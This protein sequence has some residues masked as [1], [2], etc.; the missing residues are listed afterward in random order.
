MFNSILDDSFSAGDSQ[1]Q[2]SFFTDLNIDR[3]IKEVQN[4]VSGYDVS[5]FWFISKNEKVHIFFKKRAYICHIYTL[6][7]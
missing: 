7:L 3:L 2:L 4:C 1:G 5:R 6:I